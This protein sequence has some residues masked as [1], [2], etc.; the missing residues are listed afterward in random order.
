MASQ[1]RKTST[2][3][4]DAPWCFTDEHL[5][6]RETMTKFADEV[7]APGA[8]ERSA[9]GGFHLDLVPKLAE[10]GVFGLRVSRAMGGTEADVTSA[11]I[12]MEQLARVDTSLV[13]TLQAQM[14][15]CTLFDQIATDEQKRDILPA[16]VRGELLIAFALTEPQGGSDAGNLKTTA[17]RDGSDWVINGA[18]QFITNSGTEISKYALVIAATGESPNPER[19]KASVFLVPLDAPGVT[20]APGYD[21]MGWHNSDTHPLFFDDVRVPESAL[22]GTEGKGYAEALGCLTWA[23]LPIAAGSLGVAQACLDECLEFVQDRS[24]FGKRLSEHQAVSFEIGEM[25]AQVA[26]ARTLTYDGCYKVDHDLPFAQECAIAKLVC[27]E[28]CN[29]LAYRATQIHGGYGF[30]NE[31]KVARMYRDARILAIGEG[32]SHIQTMLISRSLGL[33]V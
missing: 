2:R 33:P 10:L 9:A 26:I 22:L 1:D 30:I 24:S 12:A 3:V 19:P 14:M 13:G 25:A 5:A 17:R 21:K 15:T 18:K 6:W 28:I 16:A 11:C 7:V 31:T 27:S 23:R 8:A 20:V 29:R 32:T 4:G